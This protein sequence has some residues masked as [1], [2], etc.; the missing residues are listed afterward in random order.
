MLLLFLEVPTRNLPA[1]ASA[2]SERIAAWHIAGG[3][4]SF[5]V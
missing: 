1:A 4:K 2:A 5:E 3:V